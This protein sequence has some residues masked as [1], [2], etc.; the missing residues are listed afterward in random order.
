MPSKRRHK[1]KPL[2]TTVGSRAFG[3]DL[4]IGPVGA[5]SVGA[6]DAG[7]PLRGALLFG[8][9]PQGN[10]T[11]SEAFGGAQEQTPLKGAL[12]FGN[13]PKGN[14]T[15]S[16][17]FGGAQ[18]DTPLK[19]A[20]LFGNDPRGE[21]RGADAF[22]MGDS[23]F[24]HRG[25]AAVGAEQLFPDRLHK[26]ELGYDFGGV[27]L[28]LDESSL[29]G[30]RKDPNDRLRQ[31]IVGV[32]H[33]ALAM[34]V[35][36]LRHGLNEDSIPWGRVR[37]DRGLDRALADELQKAY[38]RAPGEVL[39]IGHVRDLLEDSERMHTFSIE[40]EW[41][42]SPVQL[43]VLWDEEPVAYAATTLHKEHTYFTFRD[44]DGDVLAYVDELDPQRGAQQARIRSI[45]GAMVGLLQ[46]DPPDEGD[47]DE[48]GAPRLMRATLRDA[49][50]REVVRVE[51]ERLSAQHLRARLI[52]VRDGTEVGL[53]EDRMRR[54][55]IQT[56]VE[57]DI[58]VPRV[59]A[60]ALAT[61]LADLARLRRRGWP[62]PTPESE[63]Q[64]LPSIEEALGPRRPRRSRS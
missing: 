32:L 5:A 33:R 40:G 34:D 14:P 9:D 13:D 50:E 26:D 4:P 45:D 44:S 49:A 46:L 22:G 6:P 63:P 64:R 17:A 27:M 53:I 7:A 55:K 62:Q 57:L 60:W 35:E 56:R 24:Q 28:H 43:R 23:Q 18:E 37:R 30:I 61:L 11:G 2:A 52:D 25:A 21:P 1:P 54:G 38:R 20:L 8:N 39:G 58:A 59:M 36:R 3:A 31:R 10:P 12:L 19:G 47:V 41:D 15:G 42:T 48:R 51:E 16:D 29:A